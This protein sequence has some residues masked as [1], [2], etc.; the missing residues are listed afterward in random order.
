M[1]GYSARPYFEEVVFVR[2]CL[3]AVTKLPPSGLKFGKVCSSSCLKLWFGL[4]KKERNKIYERR[5]FYLFF[6]FF[7]PDT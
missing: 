5:D 4:I 2:K 7:Y 6:I 3:N 1:D